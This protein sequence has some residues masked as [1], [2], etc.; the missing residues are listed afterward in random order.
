MKKKKGMKSKYPL[1]PPNILQEGLG[2]QEI[3]IFSFNIKEFFH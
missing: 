3:L 2:L 1:S